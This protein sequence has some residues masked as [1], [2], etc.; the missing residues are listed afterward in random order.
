[1]LGSLQLLHSQVE[2]IA[3]IAQSLEIPSTYKKIDRIVVFGMGGSALGTHVIQSLYRTEMKYP[4]EIIN[5][6]EMPGYVN[7]KTLVILSSYSGTTE[8]I[9]FVAEL[10]RLR[11]AKIAVISAGGNLAQFAKKYKYPALVFS[12]TNNPCGSPRMGLGY[13]IVGQLILFSKFG[14]LKISPKD[15]KQ[16]V[17]TLAEYDTAYGVL[18]PQKENLAKQMARKTI[19][20]SVWF[21]ASE[22]LVGN[23]HIAANQ[24][25]ENAKRFSGYFT[26]PEIHHHL[27]EGFGYPM[28]NE[29]GLLCVLIQSPAYFD[30]MHKRYEVTRKV[31]NKNKIAFA[32]FT[33]RETDPLLEVCETLV[34]FSYVS[35]YSALLKKIDPTPIPHVDFFKKEM[36]K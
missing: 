16:I 3:E 31:L 29:R 9:L 21:I 14:V 32:V 8:E 27:L 20:R 12:T 19:D 28:Q 18:T 35:Y 34:F 6:Y 22:H 17:K 1:M 13:S 36:G 10:A 5:G 33:P 26:I 23:A 25:N 2:E 4:L 15:I 7:S 11:K 30:R 24:M